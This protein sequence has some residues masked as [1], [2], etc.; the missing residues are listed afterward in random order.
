MKRKWRKI[1]KKLWNAYSKGYKSCFF[2]C[3]ENQ[4]EKHHLYAYNYCI[5]FYRKNSNSYS[6][7][8]T[9]EYPQKMW[10]LWH[11]RKVG[12]NSRKSTEL[13]MKRR[14]SRSD[15]V[16]GEGRALGRG[17]FMSHLVITKAISTSKCSP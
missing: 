9:W 6:L 4:L 7:K 5:I 1:H 15:I 2:V 10:G 12:L 13:R 11:I 8:F 14:G 16:A 17:M 3:G